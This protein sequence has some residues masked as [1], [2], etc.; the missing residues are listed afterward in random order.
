MLNVETVHRGECSGTKTTS[1]FKYFYMAPRVRIIELLCLITFLSD[2]LKIKNLEGGRF[3]NLRL[4][5]VKVKFRPLIL[6]R[7]ITSK[8]QVI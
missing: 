7:N 3:K 1:Y 6:N 8:I 5:V 4:D 2:S